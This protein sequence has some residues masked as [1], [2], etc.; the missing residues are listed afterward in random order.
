[1]CQ[2]DQKEFYVR[3]IGSKQNRSRVEVNTQRRGF[4]KNASTTTYFPGLSTKLSKFVS[5][6]LEPINIPWLIGI[7]GYTTYHGD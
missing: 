1:M 4:K 6:I 7:G 3:R 5:I 2:K